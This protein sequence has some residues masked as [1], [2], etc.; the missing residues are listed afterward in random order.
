MS[1]LSN[2]PQEVILLEDKE[3]REE[4]SKAISDGVHLT[5]YQRTFATL[6][7]GVI[8]CYSPIF[9]PTELAII[10][11][12]LNLDD[13]SEKLFIRLYFRKHDWQR[14]SSL[15]YK[16]IKS[17][18]NAALKLRDEGLVEYGSQCEEDYWALLKKDEIMDLAQE[19]MVLPQN[20]L[21]VL[22]REELL[23]RVVSK[24]DGPKQTKINFS[25]FGELKVEKRS[26]ID[27]KQKCGEILKIH[28]PVVEVLNRFVNLFL[29][30]WTQTND[31][32]GY[33]SNPKVQAGAALM[34]DLNKRKYPAYQI[35]R[36]RPIFASREE[37]LEYEEAI[38]LEDDES[39][40][41]PELIEKWEDSR[42]SQKAKEEITYFLKRY[43]PAWIYTRALSTYVSSLESLG[44]YNEANEI[45]FKLLDQEEYLLGAR[46]SWWERLIINYS[47]HLKHQEKA[48][49]VGERAIKDPLV[50]S[51]RLLT[52]RRKLHRL[53][54]GTLFSE[55][56]FEPPTVII[57]AEPKSVP[58]LGTR[59]IY[60][61]HD[62]GQGDLQEGSVED[63]VLHR[64]Y[65]DGWS[66]YHS[67][68]ALFTMIF[69]LIFWDELFMPI[70]DVFQSPFQ[71]APLDL[72]SDA[73]FPTRR[74][75]IEAKLK[76]I[77]EEGCAKILSLNYVQNYGTFVIGGS[78]ELFTLH[79]LLS[80]TR[81][82]GNTAVVNIL[83]L[84]AEDYKH[85]CS[86]F[87]DLVVYRHVKKGD[88][89][90]QKEDDIVEVKLIEV[91]SERDRLSDS[92]RHWHSVF[93]A[94]N[95]EMIVAKVIPEKAN[96][97][98]NGGRKRRKSSRQSPPIPIPESNPSETQSSQI[99]CHLSP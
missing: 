65:K 1:L 29:L 86:G 36:S 78:W 5:Y 21:S 46:A 17:A 50:R 80:I 83:R 12:I 59:L 96:G 14:I 42:Q 25:T 11:R 93:L 8:E 28:R 24:R 95:V 51:G 87:P 52:I 43:T 79:D 20:K 69:S 22:K 44:M 30:N 2:T 13:E 54:T 88:N 26:P 34:V 37:F 76:L 92:Q 47:K 67:E 35:I 72:F 71:G 77:S 7:K 81:G 63:L 48:I 82:L 53:T 58:T 41:G 15:V 27:V 94:N 38:R 68:N 33:S 57:N 6:I 55:P 90:S 40:S 85:F 84:L 23:S 31:G 75:Q 49:E 98:E 64:W 70:P 89:E 9:L 97:P 56:E 10:S 39:V 16:E 4:E 91:K 18:P 60:E 32:I 45:L 62:N 19:E 3:D 66:G 74:E 61:W 73:F 99:L